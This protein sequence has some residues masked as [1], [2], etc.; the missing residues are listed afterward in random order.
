MDTGALDTLGILNDPKGGL[1]VWFGVVVVGEKAGGGGIIKEV[2]VRGGESTGGG[3][4]MGGREGVSK[5]WGSCWGLRESFCNL[6]ST[7]PKLVPG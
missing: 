7:D 6:T 1:G 5:G 3:E 4:I 2:A